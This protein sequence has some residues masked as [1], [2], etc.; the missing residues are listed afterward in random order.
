VR[1]A[2]V[3]DDEPANR[4]FLE[5]LMALAG[6]TVTGAGSAEEALRKIGEMPRLALALVDQELPDI[7]GVDLI[8]SLRA[9]HA[10]AL[11]VMATMHD[12]RDLIDESFAAGVDVYLVKPHGFMELFKRL[13]GATPDLTELRRLVIDQ[14]GPR[15]FKGATQP[16]APP[17]E[18]S[19]DVA[20]S[21]TVAA[22]PN[23]EPQPK[24]QSEATPEPK[25]E[26]PAQGSQ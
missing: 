22:A 9:G 24:P 25:P 6:F 21:P 10:D 8:R 17:A 23:P 16:E 3:I 1:H 26:P 14:F 4:D 15:P 5:R 12:G 20:A 19:Q 7:R 18:P 2:I 13:Q 11:L